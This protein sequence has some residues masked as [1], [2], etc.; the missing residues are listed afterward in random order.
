[1]FIAGARVKNILAEWC[2]LWISS[3]SIL[4]LLQKQLYRSAEHTNNRRI[5]HIWNY[6]NIIWSCFV[7]NTD[8]RREIVKKVL[9]QRNHFRSLLNFLFLN[10]YPHP[11][12]SIRSAVTSKQYTT[13]EAKRRES[14]NIGR[15]I[16][17]M[18][19]LFSF[20]FFINRCCHFLRPSFTSQSSAIN[21]LV[22]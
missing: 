17:L 19:C 7:I 4:L 5:S 9:Y 15:Y 3:L 16:F 14:V 8:V 10:K 21:L 6:L 12:E 20:Y 2:K 13:E 11:T 22:G 1:M 18:L